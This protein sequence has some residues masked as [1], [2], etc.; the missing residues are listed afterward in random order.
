M[1]DFRSTFGN[2]SGAIIQNVT[3]EYGFGMNIKNVSVSI[4]PYTNFGKEKIVIISFEDVTDFQYK[5]DN[6]VSLKFI[7][8]AKMNSQDDTFEVDFFPNIELDIDHS[9]SNPIYF[10]IIS[11]HF[12][13]NQ[14]SI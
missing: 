13:W 10:R 1:Q 8:S 5:Y 14:A 6:S 7:E 9:E 3:I 11:K 12:K 4:K 2:L